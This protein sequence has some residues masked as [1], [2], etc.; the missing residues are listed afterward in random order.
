MILSITPLQAKPATTATPPSPV[1]AVWPTGE[2]GPN[3][4]QCQCL[5][6]LP[7]WRRCLCTGQSFS[8]GKTVSQEDVNAFVQ[9][10]GDSNPIHGAGSSSSCTPAAA[11]AVVPGMLLASMF[12]AIIGSRFP[13]AL[14][15]SQ[16]LKFRLP[17]AVGTAVLATVTVQAGSH[18]TPSAKTWK[19]AC[20]LTAQL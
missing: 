17:A 1:R 13:G 9:L 19:A 3:A 8:A 15:L 5:L 2:A 16:T 18:S 14:Y 7:G 20:W 11:A 12:P 10:T 6:L 4:D